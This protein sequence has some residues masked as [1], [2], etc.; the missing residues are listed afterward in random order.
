MMK[1]ICLLAE[2]RQK[3]RRR[4]D[5]AREARRD[6]RKGGGTRDRVAREK[7]TGGGEGQK[8]REK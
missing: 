7:G 3:R 6:L 4:R 2:R 1:C 8:E 5:E